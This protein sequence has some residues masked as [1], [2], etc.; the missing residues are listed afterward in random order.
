MESDSVIAELERTVSE[1]RAEIVEQQREVERIA[2]RLQEEVE[3]RAEQGR[4]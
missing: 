1:C 4:G 3:V 2:N